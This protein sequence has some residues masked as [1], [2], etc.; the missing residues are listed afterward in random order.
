[1]QGE[2]DITS[3]ETLL[4]TE[5]R[6]IKV[7]IAKLGASQKAD[8]LVP[9][10]V[11]LATEITVDFAAGQDVKVAIEAIQSMKSDLVAASSSAVAGYV[12]G[13]IQDYLG[14]ITGTVVSALLRA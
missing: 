10:L 12:V 13:R 4:E 5:V 9:D 14:R 7:A 2:V 11:K 3:T 8:E 1:M 6:E